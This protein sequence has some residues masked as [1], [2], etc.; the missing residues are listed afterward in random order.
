MRRPINNAVFYGLIAALFMILFSFVLYLGGVGLYLGRIAYLGYAVS[1]GLAATATLAQKKQNG[2]WLEFQEALRIAFT[3]FVITLVA[4]TL[5]TWILVNFIDTHFKASL[6]TVELA[7]DAEGMKWMGMDK[8]QVERAIAVERSKDFFSLSALSL[9][10]AFVCI[11]HF[12]IALLIA[13]IVK[14][15]K[16]E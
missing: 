14:K 4:Q 1:I 6:T 16:S 3:V 5:F 11:V 8:D 15:K 7:R 9:S 13:A 2:G 12:I 10:L